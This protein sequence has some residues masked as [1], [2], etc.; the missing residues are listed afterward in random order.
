MTSFPLSFSIAQLGDGGEVE[1]QPGGHK[2][3]VHVGD[4]APLL[5]HQKLLQSYYAEIENP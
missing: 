3:L 1:A 2:G 5:S 4:A